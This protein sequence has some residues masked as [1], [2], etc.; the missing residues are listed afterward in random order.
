[1]AQKSGSIQLPAKTLTLSPT[2]VPSRFQAHWL[3]CCFSSKLS[4]LLPWV[5]CVFCSQCLE[6]SSPRSIFLAVFYTSLRSF[7]GSYL[8]CEIL[9]D[10]FAENCKNV[11]TLTVLIS[12][13]SHYKIAWTEQ[14]KTRE[15]SC[16]TILGAASLKLKYHKGH[17]CSET[18]RRIL[19]FF[20]ASGRGLPMVSIAWL[21]ALSLLTL[22][23]HR[24]VPSLCG[25]CLHMVILF[26]GH[27]S[28]QRRRPA[29]ILTSHIYYGPI[30]K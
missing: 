20:L 30:S 10:F 11:P 8:L 13:G 19:C 21:V 17:P 15:I 9:P 22:L 5:L 28:Y 4:V 29:L 3:P 2:T 14:L 24:R 25:L 1:M 27:W 7:L 16:V 18:S 26:W 12:W 23:C 6:L